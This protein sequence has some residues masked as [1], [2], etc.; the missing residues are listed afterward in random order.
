[1]SVS[2]IN[3]LLHQL[4]FEHAET[5]GPLLNLKVAQKR[6]SAGAV[7]MVVHPNS[8]RCGMARSINTEKWLGWISILPTRSVPQDP[9][10]RS[11]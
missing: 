10:A 7:A 5:Y 3:N 11:A 6:T 9:C 4:Y 1:M 2:V 8:A